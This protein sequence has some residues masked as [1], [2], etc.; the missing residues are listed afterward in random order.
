MW[1]PAAGLVVPPPLGLTPTVRVY[2][3]APTV[4]EPSL[5]VRI[6]HR[7]LNVVAAAMAEYSRSRVLLPAAA[8]LNVTMRTLMFP[9]APAA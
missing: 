6:D 5:T 7:F 1:V 4:T 9:V 8:T 3:G 2:W